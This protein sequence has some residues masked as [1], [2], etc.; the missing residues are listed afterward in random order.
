MQHP[1]IQ[2]NRQELA[3]AFG[4]IGTDFPLIV[5]MIL[6]AGLH[7]PGVLI[8][9]GLMQIAT[10]LLYR[11]PMPV[12]PL[13]A[14]ATLVI[15]QKIAGPVLLGAGLAIGAVMLV[16]SVTGLLDW[17]GRMVPKTVIRGIQFGLGLSLCGLALREYIPSS[18]YSGYL[19]AGICFVLILALIRNKKIPAALVVIA[20]GIVYASFTS[21]R[22]NDLQHSLGITLP[23]PVVPGMQDIWKGFLLLVIPQIPLSLS[24]SILATRQVIIDFYPE[25]NI[26]LKKIGITYAAMNLLSPL[27]GGIPVCHGAGGMVGHYTFGGRTGG[28]VIIYGTIY[29]LLGLFFG[30]GF[31]NL[32][33]AFP[34]PVLG[35]ILLF[36]G[37]ALI[38]L[39]RDVAHEE[40][41]FFLVIMVGLLAFGLPYGFALALVVGLVLHYLS[42][43]NPFSKARKKKME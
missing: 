27:A 8:V 38:L 21:L 14:M 18:G 23:E 34:L 16:F 36:E 31:H 29:V 35:T 13:K 33:N 10:G 42:F 17:L 11:M 19:L 28:S 7:T 1:P 40:R 41:E 39:M 15:A 30:N 9:F 25:R 24:N 26:S 5:G 43:G 3:G 22:V 12:Q 6:A 20:L 37:L 2:F 32:V 4:D